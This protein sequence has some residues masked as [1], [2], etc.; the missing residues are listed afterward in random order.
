[1]HILQDSRAHQEDD[2][3]GNF[4]LNKSSSY[5]NEWAKK[6]R[7][8]L[9]AQFGGKCSRCGSLEDLEFAHVAKTDVKGRGRGRKERI[10]DVSQH[11]GSYLL[12]CHNC[13]ITL[14][15]QIQVSVS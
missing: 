7:P 9:I 14:D 4:E 6:R 13:H 8:V 2:R 5:N 1:M 10:Q 15:S 3:P 12:L 11:R